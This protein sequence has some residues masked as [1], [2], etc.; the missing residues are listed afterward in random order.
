MRIKYISNLEWAEY[1]ARVECND[2]HGHEE[3]YRVVQSYGN[4]MFVS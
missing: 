4:Q 3:H 2:L 1:S